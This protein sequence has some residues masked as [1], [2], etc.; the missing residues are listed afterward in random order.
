MAA[1]R[2]LFVDHA[3]ALGGAENSL[4][5]FLEEID[6]SRFVP[7]LATRP[8]RLADAARARGVIVH[9]AP[10]VRVRRTLGAPWR[11]VR[12]TSALVRIIRHERITLVHANTIRASIYAA[13]AARSTARPLIW[14]VRDISARGIY[15]R[16]LC[17]AAH[18]A[19]CVS[20]AAAAPLTCAGKVQVV[21]EAVRAS[22]FDGHEHAAARLRAEWGVPADAV[23]IGHV[24]RL[25]PWKGQRE[26]IAAAELLRDLPNVHVALIGGDIFG[27]APDYEGELRGTVAARRL[28]RVHITGHLDD[29]RPAFRALD[30]AVHAS[31]LEPFGR[32]LIEA[33]AAGLPVVG[34][35]SGGVN[36]IVEHGRTGFLVPFGDR[37]GLAAALRRLAADSALRRELGGNARDV[38]RARFDV[39]RLTHAVEAILEGVHERHGP[40]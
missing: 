5:L 16:S 35:D 32:V 26:V 34:Y 7:H 19:I 38:V 31:T 21:H 14:H 4:L 40:I 10:L 1:V 8:G 33:G 17:A 27:S 12:G 23:L 22:D 36:E 20:H 15:V 2:V 30:V 25:Q 18:A 11:L 9:E 28:D 37:A 3:R 6:R 24:A 39:H 13:L 29:V